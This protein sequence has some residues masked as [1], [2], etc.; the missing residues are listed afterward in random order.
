M[1]IHVSH[2]KERIAQLKRDVVTV[3]LCFQDPRTPVLAKCVVFL[4]LAYA[5][6]PIDLIPDFIPV[7]GL[8]DDLILISLGVALA[9]KL[10]PTEVWAQ[11]KEQAAAYSKQD[12]HIAGVYG[13]LIVGAIWLLMALGCYAMVSHL[14]A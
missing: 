3:Y 8:L 12:I 11:S 9:I 13:V 2:V 5:V 7:L 10:I 6:S 14:G 1:G 4:V